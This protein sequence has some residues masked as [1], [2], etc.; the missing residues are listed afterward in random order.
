MAV[1]DP[2]ENGNS[3]AAGREQFARSVLSGVPLSQARTMVV[4]I[5]AGLGAY[6]DRPNFLRMKQGLEKV[7]GGMT[8]SRVC[9]SS[10]LCN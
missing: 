8:P 2:Y 5:Q 4:L 6:M 7:G 9:M 3:A 10:G 1:P